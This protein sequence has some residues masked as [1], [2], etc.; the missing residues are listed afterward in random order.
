VRDLDHPALQ[1]GAEHGKCALAEK[2]LRSAPY[3]AWNVVPSSSFWRRSNRVRGSAP[4]LHVQLLAL[5]EVY[6]SASYA[7]SMFFQ[8]LRC[9]EREPGECIGG[10][11]HA[12]IASRAESGRSKKHVGSTRKIEGVQVE[13]GLK[14]AKRALS[15]LPQRCA[16]SFCRLRTGAQAMGMHKLPHTIGYRC[17]CLHRCGECLGRGGGVQE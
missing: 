10:N 11:V 3:W 17:A 5:F 15:V 4:S 8:F 9:G 14:S 12:R 6:S 1:L 7:V 13:R 2:L 16:G